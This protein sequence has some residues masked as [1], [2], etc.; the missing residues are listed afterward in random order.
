MSIEQAL[1]DNTAAIRELIEA[2]KQGVPTTHAQDAAV[3]TE[4][5]DTKPTKAE[6]A[7]VEKKADAPKPEA[8]E[9]SAATPEQK[10]EAAAAEVSLDDVVAAT[11][12]LGKAGKRQ[13]LVEKLGELGAAKASALPDTEWAGYVEWANALL[14]A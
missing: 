1:A 10:E 8:E 3:V 4:A 13:Q 6:K 14:E 2:L 11:L 12:A 5:A 7:K 9:S